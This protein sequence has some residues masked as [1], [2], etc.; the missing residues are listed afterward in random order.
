MNE[1]KHYGILGMHW[2]IRRYQNPD[3]TLTEK[4]KQRIKK[5]YSKAKSGGYDEQDKKEVEIYGVKHISDDVDVLKRGS[6]V[7]RYS[8]NKKETLSKGKYVYLTQQDNDVYAEMAAEGALGFDKIPKKIFNYKMSVIKDLKV[9]PGKK[10]VEDILDKYGNVKVRNAYSL[11]KETDARNK[12][13]FTYGIRNKKFGKKKW[14]ADQIVKAKNEVYDFFNNSIYKDKKINSE[15]MKKYSKQGY[16]AMVDA[17]DYFGGFQY[18]LILFDSKK[19]VKV[20][21]V[22]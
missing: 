4:G 12:D 8:D 1:L 3:G 9:V 21:K 2:G 15:L 13:E 17:E 5:I 16:N 11:Y 19:S 6:I 10:V 22:H 14:A 7:G 18:P 20:K